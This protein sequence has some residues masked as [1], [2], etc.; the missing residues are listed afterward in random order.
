M[1][2][3][4][5]KSL[6]NNGIIKYQP[7]NKTLPNKLPASE[8]CFMLK[9]NLRYLFLHYTCSIIRTHFFS[10]ISW[11]DFQYYNNFLILNI[12]ISGRIFEMWYQIANETIRFIFQ[13]LINFLRRCNYFS[14]KFQTKL[15]N[16]YFIQI[17]PYIRCMHMN[18][19]H[20]NQKQTFNNNKI[21]IIIIEKLIWKIN[22]V[23]NDNFLNCDRRKSVIC[24]SIIK[25]KTSNNMVTNKINWIRNIKKYEQWK[26]KLQNLFLNSACTIVRTFC[27]CCSISE[28]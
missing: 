14:Y 3:E 15:I 28:S 22:T 7:T 16:N 4:R 13:L 2:S 6:T 24:N 8:I 23:I 21:I 17:K 9:Q 27:C 1:I 26:K 20:E 11:I 18:S 19:L 12:I 25:S 5:W 10:L